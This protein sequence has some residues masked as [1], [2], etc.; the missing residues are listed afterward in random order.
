MVLVVVVVVVVVMLVVGT[1]NRVMREFPITVRNVPT[2]LD[3]ST[4]SG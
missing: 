4:T 1:G 3:C 2:E